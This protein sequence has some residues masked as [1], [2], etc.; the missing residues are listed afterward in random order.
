M[1]DRGPVRGLLA[2]AWRHRT[3]CLLAFVGQV[4][5]LG[6]GLGALG[7]SGLAIDVLRRALDLHAPVPR[8]PLGLSPPAAWSVGQTVAA[9]GATA[10]AFAAARAAIVWGTALVV[11]RLVHLDLVPELRAHVYDKLLRLG[12]RFFDRNPGG[13]IINRVTGD[14]QSVR[15]F[16]DGVLLQGGVLLLTLAVY[17][18]YMVRVHA[19]LAAACLAPTPLTLLATLRFSRW[20]R[21]AYEKNRALADA[22]VL[23]F[24]D[25]VKG[26]RVVKTFGAED[27]ERARFEAHNRAVRDQ[28]EEIF[29][30]VSRLGPTVSFVTALDVF[31]L[32]LYGG[33]LVA[34][35]TVTLG[36]LVV[37]AGLLQQFSTQVSGMATVLNT[38]EQSVIAARRVFE[39]LDAPLEIAPPARPARLPEPARGAV[40]F[41]GVGFGYEPSVPVLDGIDLAVEPGRCV[42]ITG[43][44]GAGKSTLLALVARFFDPVRGEILVDGVDVRTLDLAD[45][46]RRVGV[47]FQE[48]FLFRGTVADNIAFGRP[49]AARDAVERAA[50]VA[51]A[52]GFV[53]ALPGGYDTVIEEGGVDLSGGQRQRLAI[54][55]ALLLDP[56]ILLLDDPTSALDTETEGEV[57]AAVESARRGRTTLLVTHRFKALAAADEVLVLHAGR[58]VERGT[59]AA[60]LAAGGRYARAAALDVIEAQPESRFR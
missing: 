46:R 49:G 25:G 51:G 55:R 53:T 35:G 9:I 27:R 56:A 7:A 45:L 28:Q 8:W 59:P 15:G 11:G 24:T 34:G 40:R 1:P 20:A 54:A 4:A 41:A 36:Q 44:T 57:L 17:V 14:V 30:R 12:P 52:H 47:V 16:T 2:L 48:S 32:L 26:I 43:A 10:L 3:L 42:A 58:V 29:R 38:L 31:V 23:G 50:R 18:A 37:F 39:V 60:L 33:W 13:S 19:G 5:T 22:M 21:P 6:L